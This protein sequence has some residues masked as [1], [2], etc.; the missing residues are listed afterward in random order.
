MYVYIHIYIFASPG[1]S[2]NRSN[3][4]G[5]GSYPNSSGPR[6]QVLCAPFD[7]ISLSAPCGLPTKM[8]NTVGGP[9]CLAT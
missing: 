6:D 4:I 2:D 5:R 3:W 7:I 1:H 8:A 9:C